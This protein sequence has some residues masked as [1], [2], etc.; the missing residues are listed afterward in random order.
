MQDERK[1]LYEK[2]QKSAPQPG[3]E[4]TEEEVQET[5]GAPQDDHHVQT[6]A[7][8]TGASTPDTP[9]AR[10]LVKLKAEQARLKEIASSFT[11]SHVLPTETVPGQSQQLA[12]AVQDTEGNCTEEVQADEEE[13]LQEQRELEMESVD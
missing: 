2:L 11:V 3:N 9:L 4:T 6:T 12:A 13:G 1:N 8:P 10:E 5:S 7:V